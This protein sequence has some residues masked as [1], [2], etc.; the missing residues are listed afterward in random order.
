MRPNRTLMLARVAA[1]AV[2][3]VS[4]AACSAGED[5][6]PTGE[7]AASDGTSS[8]AATSEEPTSDDPGDGESTDESPSDDDAQETEASGTPDLDDVPTAEVGDCLNLVDLMGQ[9]GGVSEIPTVDCAEDH[10]AQVFALVSL[11]DGD[12][13]GEDALVASSADECEA[14]FEGFV[15][16]APA[17]SSLSYDGIPPSQESWDVGDREIICLAFY[18]DLQTTNESFEGSGI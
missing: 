17:D 11:P 3:A 14:E 7:E 15:G 4:L 5:E 12:Y 8:D 18:D 13:P 6:T 1:A 16:V 2:I 10:D 9:S